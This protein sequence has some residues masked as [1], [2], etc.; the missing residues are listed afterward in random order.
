MNTAVSW[1][2]EKIGIKW[3]KTNWICHVVPGSVQSSISFIHL[4]QFSIVAP[5]HFIGIE[6]QHCI[7][8]Q[9]R[10]FMKAV[11]SKDEW[12]SI[13]QECRSSGL[14]DKVWCREHGIPTSSFY[15][16]IRQFRKQAMEIP[17]SQSIEKPVTVI[18]EVVPLQFD[19]ETSIQSTHSSGFQYRPEGRTPSVCINAGEI[20]V[21]CMSDVSTSL[22]CSII[23]TLRTRC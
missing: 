4:L 2:L 9:R 7:V 15:Y 22:V 1:Q 8:F 6:V 19:E 11:R 13:I 10:I 16:N 21:T 23:Q 17:Q 12:F 14:P 3:F 20:T 18:Q 5:I